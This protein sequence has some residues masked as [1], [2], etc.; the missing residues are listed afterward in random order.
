M[1]KLSFPVGLR[2]EPSALDFVRQRA[3]ELT[4]AVDDWEYY[5]AGR[6]GSRIKGQGLY[7][8]YRAFRGLLDAVHGL[9]LFFNSTRARWDGPRTLPALFVQGWAGV[10]SGG[11]ER[12]DD[13]LSEI[14]AAVDFIIGKL[15]VPGLTQDRAQRWLCKGWNKFADPEQLERLF[16]Q[17]YGRLHERQDYQM[18]GGV[19]LD[20]QDAKQLYRPNEKP[21]EF[22]TWWPSWR[23]NQEGWQR[24]GWDHRAWPDA[25][26]DEH[27][28]VLG[29]CQ[30]VN[31][32]DFH[33]T[34]FLWPSLVGDDKPLTTWGCKLCR[35]LRTAVDFLTQ[36]LGKR[37][38][39][40]LA[41]EL[42]N[43]TLVV[44]KSQPPCD[45]EAITEV[46]RIE[47][48]TGTRLKDGEN[49]AWFLAI[50]R[51]YG[52]RGERHPVVTFAEY[53]R[54]IAPEKVV[55]PPA[56]QTGPI[57]SEEE[58]LPERHRLILQAMLELRAVDAASRQTADDVV[59]KAGGRG[60]DADQ[61]KHPFA[62]L[63]RLKM[64]ESQTGRRGGYWLSPYGRQQAEKQCAPF[65]H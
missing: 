36:I 43:R 5:V 16:G 35:T 28:V 65:R 8:R 29:S 64:L 57:T 21:K 23:R 38:S 37:R 13:A 17:L 58:D 30:S 6:C 46:L 49:P 48:S 20:R 59:R 60:A 1:A 26:T 4:D 12:V 61:F 9:D 40:P 11:G 45:E 62:E 42:G 15:D 24:S 47:A 53:C 51:E 50:Y 27:L 2:P 55:V 44:P 33:A 39:W 41:D 14:L 22:V 34:G 10:E 31:H 19:N 54:T 63:V 52:K 56:F 7:R 32:I 18:T 3:C 25:D